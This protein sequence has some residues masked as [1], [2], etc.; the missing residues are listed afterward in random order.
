MVDWRDNYGTCG[1]FWKGKLRRHD[2]KLF[3]NLLGTFVSIIL[4]AG[5]I[6]MNRDNLDGLIYATPFL[7]YILVTLALSSSIASDAPMT[8]GE[9]VILFLAYVL[10]YV[11]SIGYLFYAYDSEDFDK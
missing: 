7:H 2:Y 4:L 9:K 11:I 6:N 5:S 3:F 10:Q 1:A 8:I